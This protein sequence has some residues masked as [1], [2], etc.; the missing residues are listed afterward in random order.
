MSAVGLENFRA[1]QLIGAG[2]RMLKEKKFTSTEV[3]VSRYQSYVSEPSMGKVDENFA[4][5]DLRIEID[6]Q[7]G[8][9][10]K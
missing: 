5:D 3:E 9:D 4:L 2:S 10:L 8:Q 7:E 1:F 6:D